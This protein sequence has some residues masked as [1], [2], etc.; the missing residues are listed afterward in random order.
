MA[1][2]KA[3]TASTSRKRAAT[4]KTKTETAAKRA[5]RKRAVKKPA[6]AAPAAE[7]LSFSEQVERLAYQYWEERGRP[8]GSAHEDWL[9]AEAEL[10][11]DRG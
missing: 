4:S 2:A 1:T 8:D 5:P 3:A 10:A 11:A 6:G 9:R 7:G